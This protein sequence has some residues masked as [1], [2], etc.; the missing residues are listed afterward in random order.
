M[1]SFILVIFTSNR[2]IGFG[3]KGVSGLTLKRVFTDMDGIPLSRN[4]LVREYPSQEIP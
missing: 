1:V 2:L 3:F 4:T